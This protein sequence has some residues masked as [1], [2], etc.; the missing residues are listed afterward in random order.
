[1]SFLYFGFGGGVGVYFR[2]CV[3][4]FGGV[5]ILYGGRLITKF[6]RKHEGGRGE[7]GLSKN[8]CLPGICKC[9]FVLLLKGIFVT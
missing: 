4:G 8:T 7:D 9:G 5:C 1:M 6:E 3:L 2:V